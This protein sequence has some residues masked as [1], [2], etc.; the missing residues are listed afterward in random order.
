M[1]R[2]LSSE[3]VLSG[4]RVLP[5]IGF[6]LHPF[7]QLRRR[8][9]AC[10]QSDG[11]WPLSASNKPHANQLFGESHILLLFTIQLQGKGDFPFSFYSSSKLGPSSN[12]SMSTYI[13]IF[14]FLLWCIKMWPTSTPLPQLGITLCWVRNTLAGERKTYSKR[15]RLVC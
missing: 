4:N 10:P 8:W 2:S 13:Y 6:L 12:L 7:S 14:F 11:S 15:V 3:K 5:G 1:Q 9:K